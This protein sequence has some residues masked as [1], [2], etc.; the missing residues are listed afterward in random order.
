MADNLTGQGI[1]LG[2]GRVEVGPDTK[3]PSRRC[4]FYGFCTGVNGGNLRNNR[5]PLD[6]VLDLRLPAGSDLNGITVVEDAPIRDPP[7]T[8]PFT[9]FQL[10]P[11]LLMSKERATSITGSAAG[12]RTG[13]GMVRSSACT[14]APILIPFWARPG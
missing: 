1:A 9:S 5:D 6:P 4:F 13:S 7:T 2:E 12:S 3:K 14:S 8:P 11:G 10:P